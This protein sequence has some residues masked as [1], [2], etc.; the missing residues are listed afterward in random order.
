MNP[1]RKWMTV[2]IPAVMLITA[3]QKKSPTEPGPNDPP[4]IITLT[5]VPE[6]VGFG[7]TS[8]LWVSVEDDKKDRLSFRW[9]CE[10]G[11]FSDI[12]ST[13]KIA[14]SEIKTSS[15]S[16]LWTAP[17]SLGTFTVAVVV[18][19]GRDSTRA[20]KDIEVKGF[21]Y[22]NFSDSLDLWLQSYCDARVE[23]GIMH[24]LGNTEGY[25]AS[26][27]HIPDQAVRPEYTLEADVAFSGTPDTSDFYGIF[28]NV[29]DAGYPAVTNYLFAVLPGRPDNWA[30]LA[31]LY[32]DLNSD[33]FLLDSQSAGYSALFDTG[34]ET[35]VRLGMTMTSDK[36]VRVFAEGQLIYES[37]EISRLETALG[38]E[39]SVSARYF[40][41][42]GTHGLEVLCDEALL[43][44]VR[45]N[46]FARHGIMPRLLP[47][48]PDKE[49]TG[50][51]PFLVPLESRLR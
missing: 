13:A 29:N 36:R 40:G 15:D 2:F 30:L 37:D 27:S 42:R 8:R 12:Q 7:L 23:N 17:D 47:G 19:D 26:L 33:W 46:T 21:F 51:P 32:D 28:F 45:Q 49:I 44:A 3:C 9:D 35:F 5:A 34:E 24:M 38:R 39:L 18:S 6:A 50:L 14:A 31:Y 43:S 20:E 25:T 1:I 16:I 10:A 4:A 41:M 11:T 22:D 48:R